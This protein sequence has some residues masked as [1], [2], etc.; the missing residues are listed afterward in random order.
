VLCLVMQACESQ[1]DRTLPKGQHTS[2]APRRYRSIRR[3]CVGS[4]YAR[5]TLQRSAECSEAVGDDR[6]SQRPRHICKPWARNALCEASIQTAC[7]FRIRDRSKEAWLGCKRGCKRERRV[8][9]KRA[10]AGRISAEP[11]ERPRPAGGQ[12]RCVKTFGV[13]VGIITTRGRARLL[14]SM[15]GEAW[16]AS[17]TWPCTHA[18]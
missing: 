16:R 4:L 18:Y 3:E 2:R 7:A 15:R 11:G 1:T 12:L 5:S 8:R 13:Y 10:S 17:P 9:T 14:A 6:T